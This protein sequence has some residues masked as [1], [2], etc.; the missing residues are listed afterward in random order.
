MDNHTLNPLLDYATGRALA[1]ED[2]YL[3]VASVVELVRA[4]DVDEESLDAFMEVARV[5]MDEPSS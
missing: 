5:C 2:M 4:G 3:L 1:A